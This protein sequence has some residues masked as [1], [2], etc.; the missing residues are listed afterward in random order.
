MNNENTPRRG[1]GR[2]SKL[3]PVQQL[4]LLEALQAGEDKHALAAQLGV[5]LQTINRIV[6]KVRP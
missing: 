2:P 3:T 4:Q 6:R 5:S 1:R